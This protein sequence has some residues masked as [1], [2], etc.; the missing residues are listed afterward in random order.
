MKLSMKIKEFSILITVALVLISGKL[1]S[2]SGQYISECYFFYDTKGNSQWTAENPEYTIHKFIINISVSEFT[3]KGE[4]TVKDLNA[5]NV[6]THILN[7]KLKEVYD[8][9][10]EQI[11]IVY[12]ASLNA[13]GLSQL[14]TVHL[15]LDSKTN[16]LN[17]IVT[18]SLEF[19]S[20]GNY[21]RIKPLEEIS[22][23]TGSGFI[24]SNNGYIITN[25]HVVRGANK[26]IVKGI[27]GNN[28]KAYVA[29][30]KSFDE[31]NDIALLKIQ[32]VIIM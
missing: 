24:V 16:S 4:I 31:I 7:G 25:Y 29:T 3:G 22:N 28:E 21:I 12:A 19:K 10:A 11:S 9:D 32:T 14:E 18:T 23:S 26:I 5:N 30:L 15:I 2:Q 17:A 1:F 27:N 6:V 8:K 13:Y 20:K